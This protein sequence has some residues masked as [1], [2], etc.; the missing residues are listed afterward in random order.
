MRKLAVAVAIAMI[1]LMV[2]LANA[3]SILVD[4]AYWTGTR[5]GDNPSQVI[6][7]GVW[8]DPGGFSISWVITQNPDMTYHYSYTFNAPVGAVSHWIMEVSSNFTE[9][10]IWNIVGTIDGGLDTYGISQGNPGIPGNIFGIKWG[11]DQSIS[12]DSDRAPMWGDF[13]AKDGMAGGQ[14]QNYAYNTGFGTDPTSPTQSFDAWI[15]VPDTQTT[16]VPEPTTL[17]LFGVGLAGLLGL[18]RKS[19]R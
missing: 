1:W 18:R 7:N 16:T 9:E 6:G 3:D 15:P 4:P 11:S 12:F 13:Y 14:G 2:P 5:Y 19:N 17:A 10:N 8:N